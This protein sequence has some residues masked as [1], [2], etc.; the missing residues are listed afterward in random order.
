MGGCFGFGRVTASMRFVVYSMPVLT[1]GPAR[2]AKN[3]L[4]SL[5]TRRRVLGEIMGKAFWPL[6]A[7]PTYADSL[8]VSQAGVTVV[9]SRDVPFGNNQRRCDSILSAEVTSLPSPRY[10]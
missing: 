1:S 2:Y 9:R 8:D 3:P 5:C 6:R 7:I 10:R 4:Q